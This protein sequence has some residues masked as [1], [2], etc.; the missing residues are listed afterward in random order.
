M[1]ITADRRTNSI[2]VTF[3]GTQ[4]IKNALS[5]ANILPYKGCDGNLLSEL[6]GG[7]SLKNEGKCL[8]QSKK[9]RDKASSM[10]NYENN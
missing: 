4:S 5:D 10:K 8:E 1:Y 2:Y 3:R 7:F 9:A 6:E